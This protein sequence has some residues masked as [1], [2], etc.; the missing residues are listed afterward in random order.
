MTDKAMGTKNLAA[1]ISH[2][3]QINIR[4]LDVEERL[5]RGG[6]KRAIEYRA[7]VAL[8]RQIAQTAGLTLPATRVILND[9]VAVAEV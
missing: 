5:G 3:Y 2:L 1:L 4:Y 8:L 6:A 7:K 9:G